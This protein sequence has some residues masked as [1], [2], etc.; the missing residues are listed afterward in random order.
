MCV[1]VWLQKLLNLSYYHTVSYISNI[2]VNAALRDS[3]IPELEHRIN[4]RMLHLHLPAV[5]ADRAPLL[6]LAPPLLNG[7]DIFLYLVGGGSSELPPGWSQ[8]TLM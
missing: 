1:C 8:A 2:L 6:L 3:V 5:G 7:T 4:V